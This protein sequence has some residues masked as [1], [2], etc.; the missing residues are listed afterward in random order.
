MWRG[1]ERA[2]KEILPTLTLHV[3]LPSF[4]LIL[5][6]LDTLERN[7]WRAFRERAKPHD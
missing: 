2:R 6:Q 4:V 3:L 7:S 5:F 1:S